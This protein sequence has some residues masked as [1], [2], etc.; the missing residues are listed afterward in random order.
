VPDKAGIVNQGLLCHRGRFGFD[1]AVSAGRLTA[2]LMREGGELR[3]TEYHDA[4]MLTAKGLQRAQA[5]YGADAAAIAVS[6]RLTNEE[7]YAIKS[8]GDAIGARVV[9][10]ENAPGGLKNVL[11]ADVSPNTIDELLATELVIAVGF[12]PAESPVV[13]LKLRRAAKNGVKIVLINPKEGYGDFRYAHEVVSAPNSVKILRETLAA[14][15][16]GG[17]S[18]ALPGFDELKKDLGGTEPSAPAKKLAEL[19]AGAKKAMLVFQQGVVSPECAAL[20]ADLALVSGH[21][22][23][24]RDGILQIRPKNNS[25]GLIDLGIADGAEALDGVKA[26]LIFGEDPAALP[27]GIA[28]VAVCDTHLTKTAAAADVVLPGTGSAAADGT[29]TN[30]ERRLMPV[31]GIVGDGRVLG[32]WEVAQAVARVFEKD[33]GWF[34][35]SDISAEMADRFNWYDP[36]ALG[37]VAP[38]PAASPA[39]RIVKRGKLTDKR[40][41]AD[42]LKARIDARLWGK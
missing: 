1:G 21:L 33:A 13:G 12:D 22:G 5:I 16:A 42:H 37:A 40:A 6:P 15:I 7:A 27:E 19:Y 4:V 36:A 25:Q 17:K 30:T 26:L 23:S 32:N 20:L 2:P 9:S 38:A 34:D 31:R 29:F 39:L 8:L 14:L 3:E 18:A 35:A 28:F 24:P 11:G 10:F 41:G